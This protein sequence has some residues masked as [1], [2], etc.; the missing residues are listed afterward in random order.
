MEKNQC[1]KV[2]CKNLNEKQFNEKKFN[3][4]NFFSLN[5]KKPNIQLHKFKFGF[6]TQSKFKFKSRWHRFTSIVT[7]TAAQTV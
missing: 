7:H 1:K 4:M 3:S 6:I 5:I 2:K